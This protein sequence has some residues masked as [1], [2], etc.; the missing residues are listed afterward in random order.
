MTNGEFAIKMTTMGLEGHDCQQ[1]EDFNRNLAEHGNDLMKWDAKGLF[2]LGHG[3]MAIYKKTDE[4][5]NHIEQM[6]RRLEPE[7][8]KTTDKLMKF[9]DKLLV[10]PDKDD[11]IIKALQAGKLKIGGKN[12]GPSVEDIEKVFHVKPS[13]MMN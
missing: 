11:M 7:K 12:D 6:H 4:V 8:A 9:I 3:L 13:K 1:V 5:L 2:A 10:G